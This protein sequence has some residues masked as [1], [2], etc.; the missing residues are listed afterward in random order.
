MKKILIILTLLA[1]FVTAC[2]QKEDEDTLKARKIMEYHKKKFDN[3]P[4][5]GRIVNG[6]REI[7]IKAMQYRWE[8]EN[9][10]VKKGEKV[11]FIIESI[12]VPHGFEL[13]GIVIPNWDP[14]KAIRKDDKAIL[15]IT[16]D[17]AG[18]WDLVCTIYCGP[19]HSGMKG[20][21]IVRE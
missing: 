16:A 21:Y 18:T 10:I 12:D 4:L 8:P 2:S 20:K 1:F 3:L 13:E 6:M 14:D 5:S 7:E 15:E 11:R 19:G 17:E 9:I